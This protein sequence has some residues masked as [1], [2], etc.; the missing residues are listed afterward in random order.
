MGC[1]I[2]S[3]AHADMEAPAASDGAKIE[4]FSAKSHALANTKCGGKVYGQEIAKEKS[5]S[6]GKVAKGF[7]TANSPG[8][9][10]SNRWWKTNTFPEGISEGKLKATLDGDV[11]LTD[12]ES[13]S[14][15]FGSFLPI[16]GAP[17]AKVTLP[18]ALGG[19]AVICPKVRAVDMYVR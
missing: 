2:S 11:D 4:M 16:S 3:E 6:D 1:G 13:F 14:V 9:E 18:K 12:A 7:A 15:I 10:A 8:K 5:S 17:V 19:N